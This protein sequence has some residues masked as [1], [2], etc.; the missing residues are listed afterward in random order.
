M[1]YQ[2]VTERCLSIEQG[3]SGR[4]GGGAGEGEERRQTLP[5]PAGPRIKVPNLDIASSAY[6]K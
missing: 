4:R 1:R 6:G 2:R 5:A 3:V